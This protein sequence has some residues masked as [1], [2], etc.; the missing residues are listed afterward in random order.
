MKGNIS[1]DIK[2]NCPFYDRNINGDSFRCES[3]LKSAKF[4]VVVFDSSE[5]KRQFMKRHCFFIDG[6]SCARAKALLAKYE[7]K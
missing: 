4:D 6:K 2:V 7:E 5:K 3:T 1:I